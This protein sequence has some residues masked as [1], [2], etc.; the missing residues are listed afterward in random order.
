MVAALACLEVRPPS[1]NSDVAPSF[2]SSG[3][4][5][6]GG[7]ELQE[8]GLAKG[9]KPSRRRAYLASN[10]IL[11]AFASVLAL[12]VPLLFKIEYAG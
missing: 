2:R 5:K 9:G 1:I 10:A 6:R 4:Q 8:F 11:S 3:W 7:S 12:P